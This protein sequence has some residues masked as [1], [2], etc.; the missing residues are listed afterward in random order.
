MAGDDNERGF[1]SARTKRLKPKDTGPTRKVGGDDT[2]KSKAGD[3]ASVMTQRVGPGSS[4][5]GKDAAP[6]EPI[7]EN[8]YV[9]GWLVILKGPGR[10]RS[11]SLRY[12]LNTAGRASTQDIAL[13]FG[14]AQI[15]RENHFSIAY[16]NKGRQ[17][18]IQHGG[19]QNLTYLNET[20]VMAATTL[21][22]GAK[23]SIGDTEL[24]FVGLCG[25]D[26]E[27]ADTTPPE[28]S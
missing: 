8:E 16:D 7:A 9:T 1:F 5:A 17:F 13:D 2:G 3:R 28:A 14:D 12:G 26:F 22:S 10:G 18:F 24:L 11:I 19:G 25:A 27:W 21:E 20:P 23:I 6:P 4:A 15:S